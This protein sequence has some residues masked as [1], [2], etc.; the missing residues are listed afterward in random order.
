VDNA[1]SHNVPAGRLSVRVRSGDRAT[2]T[3]TNTGPVVPAGEVDR[4]LQPF[5]RLSGDR[6]RHGEG[7]GLGLSIVAA[8][9]GAHD[10]V[11]SVRPRP[12]GGLEVQVHFQVRA[13]TTLS[14]DVCLAED[15]PPHRQA[16]AGGPAGVG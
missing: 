5:Q 4:L 12:E 14:R 11:L 9:A 3:V 16:A 1:I 13:V 7:V 15:G 2:L 6:T 10:A 8:V